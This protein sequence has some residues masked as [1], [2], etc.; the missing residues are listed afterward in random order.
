M[1]SAGTEKLLVWELLCKIR[2]CVADADGRMFDGQ[3]LAQQ[4]TFDVI[5][6]H[7]AAG[8]IQLKNL[9]RIRGITPGSASVAIRALEKLG[10]VRRKA[11]EG[12]RRAALLLPTE[13]ALKKI[14]RLDGMTVQVT[15]EALTGV[16]AD[17]RETCFRVLRKML[18]N[19]N[20]R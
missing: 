3:T 12:D 14:R 5:I 18:E 4:R 7:A 8:G 20:N 15:E 9:A 19:L 1:K 13:K 2:N 11:I 6:T 16:P 10:L 17:A